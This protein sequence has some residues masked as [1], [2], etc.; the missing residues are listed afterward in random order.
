M[1]SK[2]GATGAG[3]LSAFA[4]LLVGVPYALLIPWS[5]GT[6]GASTPDNSVEWLAVLVISVIIFLTVRYMLIQRLDRN[7]E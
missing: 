1:K 7:G 5:K 6:G 2:W 3:C 4:F